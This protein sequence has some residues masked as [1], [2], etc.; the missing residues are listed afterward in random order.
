[1]VLIVGLIR[2]FLA[3][4]NGV[5]DLIL[6]WRE[7]SKVRDVPTARLTNIAAPQS[8]SVAQAANAGWRP[9]ELP[10]GVEDVDIVRRFEGQ[11]NS[12]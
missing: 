1:M 9:P 12:R 3:I 7:L 11:P 10:P 4:P 6:K 5:M 8:N 2:N